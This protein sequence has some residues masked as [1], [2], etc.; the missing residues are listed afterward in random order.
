MAHQLVKIFC[1]DGGERRD[2]NQQ[3]W[4]LV[5]GG[6]LTGN[7]TLCQGEYFGFGESGCE[8]ETKLVKRGGITCPGCLTRLKYYKRIKL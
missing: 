7:A 5:D 2:I 1:D 8:F 4:H 6:N 3:F